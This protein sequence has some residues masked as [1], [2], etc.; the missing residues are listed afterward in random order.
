M[1]TD[2]KKALAPLTDKIQHL[3]ADKA[4]PQLE[5]YSTYGG[6]SKG[7]V[8]GV[9]EGVTGLVGGLVTTSN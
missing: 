4:C 5:K 1:F 2:V 7:T 6:L 9:V 8:G 3:L